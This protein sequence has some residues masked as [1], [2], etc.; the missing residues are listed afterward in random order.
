[1]H[2]VNLNATDSAGM[3]P[4]MWAA[5]HNQPKHIR[6]LLEHGAELDEKDVDGKTAF[7][8]VWSRASQPI[9]S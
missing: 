3:T 9:I 8:W 6:K 2:Q 4:L 7:H 5:F 1:M